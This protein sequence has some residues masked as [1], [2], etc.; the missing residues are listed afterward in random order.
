MSKQLFWLL[1]CFF[2]TFSLVAQVTVTGKI[3]DEAN[4]PLPGA[5]V[6]VKGT[7]HGVVSDFDGNYTIQANPGDV[8]EFS[9]IGFQTQTKKVAGGVNH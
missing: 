6:L 1:V 5:N 9:F 7:T 2:S 4:G 3:T 8:L